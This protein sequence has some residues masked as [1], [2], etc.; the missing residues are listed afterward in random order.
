MFWLEFPPAR[1]HKVTRQPTSHYLMLLRP[2]QAAPIELLAPELQ[3]V[4]CLTCL[5]E[6]S[7]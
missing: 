4:C 2:A 7:Y 5:A 3:A 6:A 1:R